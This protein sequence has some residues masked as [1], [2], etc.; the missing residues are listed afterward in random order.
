MEFFSTIN[1][2]NY[3]NLLHAPKE[4]F[5]KQGI[6]KEVK[7]LVLSFTIPSIP[8]SK[9]SFDLSFYFLKCK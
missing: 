4:K 8:F 5:T 7:L 1:L 6:F 2:K 3:V 9:T